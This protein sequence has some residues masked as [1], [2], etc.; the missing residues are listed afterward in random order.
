LIQEENAAAAVDTEL[1]DAKDRKKQQLIDAEKDY[2]KN[3][4]EEEA[5]DKAKAIKDAEESEERLKEEKHNKMVA[6]HERLLA[7]AMSES[8]VQVSDNVE[9]NSPMDIIGS[10]VPLSNEFVMIRNPLNEE[11]GEVDRNSAADIIG[12]GPEM[13]NELIMLRNPLNEER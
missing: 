12:S 6:D 7:D 5:D 1:Q 4:L 3:V 10:G 9:S 8:L 2:Q 11:R 13:N